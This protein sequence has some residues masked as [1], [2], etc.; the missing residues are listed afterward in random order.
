MAS[1]TQDQLPQVWIFQPAVKHYRLPIWDLLCERARG[2]YQL[3]VYGP[4]EIEQA[5]IERRCYLR[6]MPLHRRLLLGREFTYWP[7]AAGLIRREAPAVVVLT[8]SATFVG[9]WMLPRVARR[10]GT[11]VVGWSKVNRRLGRSAWP[12]R[13]IRQRFFRRFDLFLCYGESSRRELIDL[14]YPADRIR[15]AQNTIDTRYIFDH[16]AA[17][18]ARGEQLRHVTGVEGK[19]ILLCIGRMVPQKQHADLIT[20]WLDLRELDPN[21]VLVF[22]GKGELFEGLQEAADET[23]AER[24]V[25]TGGVPA[26]DDFAWIATAD[27]VVLPGAVGL[28]LNQSMALGK[29]TII[30]D[31][32]GADAELLQHGIN[33]WRFPRGNIQALVETVRQM[34]HDPQAAQARGQAARGTIEQRATIERMVDCID[35]TITEL[36]AASRV[37]RAQ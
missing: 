28:A 2:R 1:M 17:I 34:L 6:A 15:I 33:G 5:E 31:E 14:G 26:G 16:E 12:Q 10:V 30:A 21:L 23:D 3:T 36:L 29:P 18:R 27:L 22:V 32:P 13:R 4:L 24:I 11:A 25:F 7:G 19:K 35:G 8:A 37:G 20:A 9:S